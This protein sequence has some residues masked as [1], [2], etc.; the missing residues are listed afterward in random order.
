[1]VHE[2]VQRV[3]KGPQEK[4]PV[5]YETLASCNSFSL[6][7]A[8]SGLADENHFSKGRHAKEAASLVRMLSAL[9][10]N[11]PI[12]TSI[13]RKSFP[14]MGSPVVFCL[15]SNFDMNIFTDSIP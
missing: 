7:R 6:P 15:L 3:I 9:R 5:E 8:Q 10:N 12:Q 11:D 4:P 14:V 1:M 2:Q 13:V